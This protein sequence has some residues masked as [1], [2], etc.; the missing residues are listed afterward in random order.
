MLLGEI[1]HDFDFATNCPL[2]VTKGLFAKVYPTG[3]SHG[4]LSVPLDGHLFEVTRYRRDISTDGRRATV[5]YSD[6]IEEDQKRRD[7]RINSL[8]YDVIDGRVVDS[9]G[10]LKD[11]DGKMV[12]F[13]GNAEERILEDHLRAVRYVRTIARLKPLGFDYDRREMEQAISVFDAG[14]LSLE[15]IYEEIAKINLIRNRDKSFCSD[16]LVR[17]NLFQ[18]YFRDG[19]L[20]A[21]VTRSVVESESLFPL[22]FEYGKSHSINET[23]VTL[24]LSRKRKRVLK[25]LH[26]FVRSDF[27]KNREVKRLLSQIAVQDLEEATRAFL[28][29]FNV[30]LADRFQRII[31]QKEP[32]H[33]TDLAISAAKLKKMGYEGEK[34]GQVQ[35]F[36]QERVWE[37]PLSNRP[38]I[39][40][41]L[42]ESRRKRSV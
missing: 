5:A 34:L 29:V 16:H 30:D 9:Q 1:P 13:V 37:D 40:R 23:V 35:R 24:K 20:A 7:L 31:S 8:A 11:F 33:P 26:R 10:G 3:E 38:E 14:R 2:P 15:R 27:S 19:A 12:R 21:S 18:P 22:C 17:L 6:C 28:V 41:Q 4:T 25:L 39:L 42:A 32:I 36:L